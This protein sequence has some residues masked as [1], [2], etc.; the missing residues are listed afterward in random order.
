MERLY[1]DYSNKNIPTPTKE[2]YKI[3]LISKVES[4]GRLES[5]NKET[6]GFKSRK[7]PRTIDD[8]IGFEDDLMSLIKNIQF[9]NVRNT[10][11]EQLANDIKQIKCTNKVIV[12]ADKTRNLYK[13][14]KENY[15]K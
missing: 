13:V 8:L 14:E 12:P 9:R 2:E 10:F 3:Q 1:T 6:Y 11:Q 4:V 5:S 7:Y 15:R